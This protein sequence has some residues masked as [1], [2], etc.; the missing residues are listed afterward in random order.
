MA[1]MGHALMGILLLSLEIG[2]EGS[3]I[4]GRSKRT[5]GTPPNPRTR[6]SL[7]NPFCVEICFL[8]DL[9]NGCTIMDGDF[10]ERRAWIWVVMGMV[11][12]S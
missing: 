7:V 2:T 6:E 4:V 12:W 3:E 9:G 10:M 11:G 5:W 1:G 8:H